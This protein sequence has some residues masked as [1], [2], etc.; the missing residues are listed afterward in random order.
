MQQQRMKIP[1]SQLNVKRRSGKGIPFSH[2]SAT[3]RTHLSWINGT[4]SS[5]VNRVTVV[6]EINIESE[7][8]DQ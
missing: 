1:F 2:V 7:T 3:F 4:V 6:I 8:K 5:C